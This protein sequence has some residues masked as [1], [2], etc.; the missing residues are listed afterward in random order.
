MKKEEIHLWDIER[1]LFGQAPPEFLVE[2]LL[3][4]LIIYIAGM[5]AIRWM[6]KRISGQTSN[7]EQAVVVMMGAIL[8]VPMQVPDRGL[9]QGFFVL[10]L[11]LALLRGVNWISFV[12]LNFEKLVQ[13]RV[14]MLIKDGV[15]DLR[16]LEKIKIT[17][18]QVF[19][20]LRAKKIFNLG[21][22]K[23]LYIE[24]C[25]TFSLY[26]EKEGRPGLPVFPIKDH[27]ILETLQYLPDKLMA[28]C[29]C[30]YVTEQDNSR[31]KCENCRGDQ[32]TSAVL[33]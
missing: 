22:V 21:Q 18:Q 10:L 11:A 1:I 7:I 17:R 27:E 8:S 33:A 25:G 20:S 2:V 19:A 14:I 16:S 6:G 5:I 31:N 13:G 26:T 12:N 24:G 9:L 3:R 28:C 32:W 30:G 29:N 23:R 15:L 4:S